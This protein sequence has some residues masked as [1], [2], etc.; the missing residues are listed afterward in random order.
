ML[1]A[2]ERSGC[3]ITRNDVLHQVIAR[4]AYGV[5]IA[6][7]RHGIDP[8]WLP[9]GVDALSGTWSDILVERLGHT[10][11]WTGLSPYQ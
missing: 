1:Q 3:S 4:G 2:F 5:A 6:L 7:V 11:L 9:T 8:F 10:F